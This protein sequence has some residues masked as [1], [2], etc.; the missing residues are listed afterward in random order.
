MD[1][2]S[3][4]DP[5]IHALGAEL[6]PVRRL[7]SPAWR[8]FGWMVLLTA[9]AALLAWHYGLQ[10]HDRPLVRPRRTWPGPAWARC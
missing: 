8:T 5:L 1:D 6:S 10:G 4:H 3:S 2:T 7:R 9:L